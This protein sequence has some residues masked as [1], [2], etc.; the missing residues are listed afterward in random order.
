[1]TRDKLIQK[2][3]DEI[4]DYFPFEKVRSQMVAENWQWL[5]LHD[6][7]IG[8]TTQ[9]PE[10]S[11]I[12]KTAREMLK[13]AS[14]KGGSGYLASGGFSARCHEGKDDETGEN[15]LWLELDFGH[16]WSCEDENY[17]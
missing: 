6:D 7:G 13:S 9:I 14:H 15:F 4:M 5:T 17:T 10:L 12:R 1:M 3:I 11:E 16:N 2:Q 8:G